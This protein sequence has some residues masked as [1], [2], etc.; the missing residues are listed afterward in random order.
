ML[1]RHLSTEMGPIAGMLSEHVHFRQLQEGLAS[2]L[3]SGDR[4]RQQ[5]DAQAIVGL[6][7]AHIGKEDGVLFLMAERL[8]APDEQAEVDRR[9]QTLHARP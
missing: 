5:A 6:L 4:T 1:G 8:S 7:C 3:K 2:A 9:A